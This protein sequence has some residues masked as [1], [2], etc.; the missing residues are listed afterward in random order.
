MGGSSRTLLS[1]KSTLGCCVSE[2]LLLCLGVLR[3]EDRGE[4][5]KSGVSRFSGDCDG[6]GWISCDSLLL[7]AKSL[8]L[9]VG[10]TWGDGGGL[11]SGS[12]LFSTLGDS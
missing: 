1:T 12:S 9:L 6:G 5:C 7:R 10:G 2:L 11:R 8:W 3:G 4:L